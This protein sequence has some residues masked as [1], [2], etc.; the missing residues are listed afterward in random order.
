MNIEFLEEDNDDIACIS[1]THRYNKNCSS[2]CDIDNHF[3]HYADM[4]TQT[5]EQHKLIDTTIAK[6]KDTDC[7]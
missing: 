4:W 1:C 5:C 7:I 2:Y 6:H 3:M